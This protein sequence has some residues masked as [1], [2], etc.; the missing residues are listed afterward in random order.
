MPITL[1]KQT[2]NAAV[3]LQVTLQKAADRGIDLG[4]VDAQVILAV[5]YSVSMA[6][7][8]KNGAVQDV[9]ER[10]LALSLTGLDNDGVVPVYPFHSEVL[11]RR[12]ATA[13]NYRGFVQT[14][15]TEAMGGTNYAPVME[16]ILKDTSH[17]GLRKWVRAT[18]AQPPVPTLV[19]F[20]TDGEP[21]DRSTTRQLIRAASDRPVFWQ[22]IG[23]GMKPSLLEELDTMSDRVLDNVGFA[24][25]HEVL[26]TAPDAA[27]Q[28]WFAGALEEFMLKWIPAA[29][30]QG[31]IR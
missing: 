26:R 30:T 16:R 27:N 31:V 10:C 6:S 13:A 19:L 3:A 4:E 5:D 2:E 22:F 18:S 21:R 24:E 12:D 8:Y 7:L 11:P 25:Y 28:Q 15:F 29:R 14:Q 20:V 17:T 9:V 1:D 23:I